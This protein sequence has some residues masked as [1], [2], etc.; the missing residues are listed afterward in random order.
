M[1]DYYE[2][3]LDG[4]VEVLKGFVAGY[5]AASGID[6]EV[7]VSREFN[8][9]HDSLAHQLAEWIGLV[10]DRTHLIV[11]AD[12]WERIRAGAERLGDR[13]QIRI[14]TARRLTEARF[15]F[16]WQTYNRDE[17]DRLRALF[18]APPEGV[19]L[20]GHE[21]EE[22]VHEEEQGRTG[23]YAPTHPYTARGKGLARG[24]PGPVIEWAG[25][26]RSDDFVTVET[27]RLEYAS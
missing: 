22:I 18:A 20:E 11:P 8:V 10:E 3:V 7:F 4:D 19:R 23:M 21:P 17:A 5:L 9:E 16:S 2:I 6:R 14:H 13:L 1:S 26:M 25:R 12:A 27:I 24:E 15:E